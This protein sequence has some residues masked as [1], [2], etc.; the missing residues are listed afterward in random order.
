MKSGDAE[1]RYWAA[2]GMGELGDARAVADLAGA[3]RS[4]PVE[5]VRLSAANALGMLRAKESVPALVAALDKKAY[6]NLGT[7]EED[8]LPFSWLCPVRWA[9]ARALGDIGD[10]AAVEPLVQQIKAAEGDYAAFLA[11]ALVRLDAREAVPALREKFRKRE[12]DSAGGRACVQ[13]LGALARP[14]DA[15]IAETVSAL[16]K[17]SGNRWADVRASAAAG[18]AALGA[19]E[20]VEPLRTLLQTEP[21]PLVRNEAAR[22]LDKLGAPRPSPAP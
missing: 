22:A 1:T 11:E 16:V 2:H 8:R 10:K 6:E 20:A 14:G 4:D 12:S 3:L 17:A 15:D 13:A 19:A 18:L 21:E 9:A 5:R 7:E